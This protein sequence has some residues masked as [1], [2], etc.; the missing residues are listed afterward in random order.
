MTQWKYQSRVFTEKDPAD[1]KQRLS[2]SKLCSR[3]QDRTP[4]YLVGQSDHYVKVI[5][6][7]IKIKGPLR[8]VDPVIHELRD[9][10]YCFPVEQRVIA[11]ALGFDDTSKSPLKDLDALTGYGH[12]NKAVVTNVPTQSKKFENSDLE[13]EVSQVDILGDKMFT[14]AVASQSPDKIHEALDKYGILKLPE[15]VMM[16]YAERIK[17]TNEKLKG[18]R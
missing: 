1:L 10:R 16:E 14:V 15:A 6:G 18:K 2:D 4:T 9:D 5:N 3:T 17:R 12:R 7:Q 11:S 8:Q 13:I